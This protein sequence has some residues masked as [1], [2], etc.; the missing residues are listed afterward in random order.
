MTYN[1]E[2]DDAMF[3]HT[4]NQLEIEANQTHGALSR[5]QSQITTFNMFQ[6]SS[7]S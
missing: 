7:A 1:G 3:G 5:F 6:K 2:C 4:P